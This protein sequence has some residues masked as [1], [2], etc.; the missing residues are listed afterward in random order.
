[1]AA[2]TCPVFAQFDKGQVA[3]FVH[4]QKSAVIPA[5]SVKITNTLTRIERTV[6]TDDSGYY[7]QL[8]LAP[9]DYEILVEAPGFKR[10]T[11][12]GVK[13]DAASKVS[14]DVTLEAG[15]VNESVTVV[16]GTASIERDSAQV[17]RTLET[18]DIQDLMLNG[19]SPLSLTMLKA[20]IRGITFDSFRPD[21]LGNGFNVNGSRNDENLVTIDGVI[22]TRTRASGAVL[23]VFNVDAIQEVKILTSNYLPEYGRSSGGQVR[24]V[25]KSGGQAF[26]GDAF[27]FF[28]NSALDA[29]S[30][31]RNTSKDPTING[32]AAPFRFNQFGFDFGGPVFIP[33]K[34]NTQRDKLFFFWAEEWIRWRQEGTSTGTVP[35]PAMRQG[36]FS[37]LLDPNNLFYGKTVLIKDPTTGQPLAGNRIPLNRL[38]ANGIAIMNSFPLP[39]PGFRNGNNNWIGTSPNP[40]DTRKDTVKVD[41][42]PDAND[43]ISFSGTLFKWISV[44]SFRGTFDLARTDWSRPNRTAAFSWTRSIS[45]TLINEFTFGAAEDL[46][47]INVFNN[48]KYQRSTYGITYPYVFPGTKDIENKI[49]T[50]QASNFSTVDGGPYPAKSKGPIFTWSDN[51]TRLHGRHI[52]KAGVF[53]EYSGENDLDQINV[54]PLPGN[55]NNQNGTFQFTDSRSGGTGAAIANM[56]LGLFTNYAEISRKS[57]TPWRALA[58]DLFVQDSWKVRDN[59]TLELGTRYSL[60]PPWH[61]LWGNIAE[62]N[63][64]FYDPARAAVVDPATG[65]IVSGDRFNGIVL[66]GSGFP[67]SAVGRVPA[68]SD[69]QFQRLFHGLP[70]G[71]SQ[72]HNAVFEPRLGIAYSPNQKTVVR[73]GGGIFLNRVTINDSTL[74][75]G[76]APIQFQVG[77]SNGLADAPTGAQQRNF[78]LAMTMQDPVF[79]LPTS[80]QY[81]LGIQRE[82]PSGIT[83]EVAYVGRVGAFLQRE[84]NI[85]QLPIGTKQANPGVNLDALRPYRGFGVIRLSENA[86]HSNYNG[87][88]VTLDRRFRSGL[89]FGVAYTMSKITSNTDSKRDLLFNTFDDRG[90]RAI[91]DLDR[92]HLLNVYYIYELPLWREQNRFYKKV[93]GG[94]Q[95]SGVTVFQS[96]QP[97]SVWRGDDVAGVGDNF[98][99]PWNVVGDTSVAHQ[100][101]SSSPGDG[102]FYFNPKAFAEPKPGTFGNAGRNILRGPRFQSWDLALFKNMKASERVKAQ[103]RWE[104]FNFP[105]HPNLNNPDT[106]PKSSTFGQVTQKT[107]NRAMQVALKLSF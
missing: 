99:Q 49:P 79:K 57:Y 21:D 4:D 91:S 85:N 6:T 72:T 36:D 33:G 2:L 100:A 103:L 76:N 73:A 93:A 1:M 107:G 15:A 37:E 54:Q 50:V 35:T 29:N 97:L 9:G 42:H 25:T 75:G 10:F 71:F 59:L 66:P 61:S 51:V 105:N 81:S 83:L 64:A 39:T 48:G 31:I 102:N 69:P 55:S 40:R 27:E 18:K 45:P 41:Y 16:G 98:N 95:I 80:Y 63:P 70:D 8:N 47:F 22:A 17:G 14:I 92:T 82:L 23:G 11:Q 24:F 89:G 77:A 28:R 3:G 68:A 88:Q 78:P 5:A 30:W 34:F 67:S 19:R 96:G 60:W 87:L 26:H 62:F 43:Q 46:V 44:D 106:N 104:I 86:G 65:A 74:L 94:W 13:V 38:S 101:F 20:G 52:L 84:R 58:T 53:F 56:A 90:F 32:R 7:I 12:T